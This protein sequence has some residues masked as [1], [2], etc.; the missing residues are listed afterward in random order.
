M[1][2]YLY[3][4]KKILYIIKSKGE[5]TVMKQYE[6]KYLVNGKRGTIYV[7]ASS[8]MS[9]RDTAKGEIMGMAGIGYDARITITGVREIR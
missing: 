1:F 4:Y 7:E 8:S 2:L 9:A 5:N 6:V 3:K